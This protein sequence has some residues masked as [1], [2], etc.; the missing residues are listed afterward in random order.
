MVLFF[1][2]CKDEECK[3]KTLCGMTPADVSYFGMYRPDYWHTYISFVKERE[4]D[5]LYPIDSLYLRDSSLC[6][7]LMDSLF[8]SKFTETR[9]NSGESECTHGI[10]T[11]MKISS[12]YF[13]YDHC[14]FQNFVCETRNFSMYTYDSIKM[15]EVAF[16]S[17][18]M[19]E[20]YEGATVLN[21]MSIPTIDTL[22]I[23]SADT[24]KVPAFDTVLIS[25]RKTYQNVLYKDN[26]W[27]APEVGIIKFVSIVT[28]D[29]FY[30]HEFHKRF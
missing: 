20:Q 2:S 28:N 18:S 24:L 14:G 22:I 15:K 8:T 7:Y 16:K 10:G 29:T 12:H 5:N 30:L 25:S 13:G 27:F 11:H 17:Q 19:S 23:P 26:L 21:I 4:T 3:N 1:V 9:Y 6:L